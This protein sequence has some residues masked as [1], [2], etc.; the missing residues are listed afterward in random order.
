MVAKSM[1][2][3]CLLFAVIFLM[4]TCEGRRK[5]KRKVESFSDVSNS[6]K[7]NVKNSSDVETSRGFFPPG[8]LFTLGKVLN[9]FPVGGER[10]CRPTGYKTAR[11]GICLNP[12]DCRQRDGQSAGDCAHGL[13]VCCVFEVSCG[14]VVQNNLTYFISPGF[15]ELWT[16]EKDCS[17]TVEKTHAGIMQL[18]IDF[19]HF[20]I[21]QP[22]RLTGECDEDAMIVGEGDNEFRVC[23][24][25]HGQHIYYTLP[26]DSEKRDS[27]DELPSS[28]STKI[29]VRM[30]GTDM[31]RLWL[32]RLA[33]MPLAHSAPHDCRQYYTGNN[34]TIRTFNYA[35]N[36]RHLANHEYRA[37][38]RKNS[39]M[40]S[41]RYSPCDNRSFRIGGAQQLDDVVGDEM[42]P[43]N[44]VQTQEDEMEGSGADP[45]IAPGV[46]ATPAPSMASRIWSYIWPSWLWQARTLSWHWSPYAQHFALPEDDKI[47]YNGYGK[48]GEG[49]QGGYGRLRCKDRITIP[50]EN[51]YFVSSSILMSGVCDPHHCGSSFCPHKNPREC[52][53]DTSITPFAVSVHFGQPSRKPNPEENIGACLRYTQMPCEA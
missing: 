32:L 14:G 1:F 24:Q 29:T 7:W 19:V 11:A 31:P 47:R 22:N 21:G 46:Q 39:G 42:M 49:L 52:H 23:G 37:C 53:V 34:G 25:N 18:R 5:I 30:R 15:P 20:T 9:F 40:C 51:E 33:Q 35:V 45:Q 43:V 28:A 13:G 10:E 17:V 50:C 6:L 41:V 48:F 44:E 12:Y 36:G 16:G 8:G 38:I 27:D 3:K 2:K 4:C 26:T